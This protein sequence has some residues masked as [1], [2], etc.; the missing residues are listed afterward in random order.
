MS[1]FL[2]A[3]CLLIG[4]FFVIVASVGLLRLPDLFI[5][6]HAATKA[7]TVGL[8]FLL[9]PVAITLQEVTVTSRI[10]SILFFILITAPVAAHLLGKAMMQKGYKIWRGN[11]DE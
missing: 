6:M 10:V 1:A 7:G 4:T 3:V 5:R 9:L 2:S 11:P 8:A